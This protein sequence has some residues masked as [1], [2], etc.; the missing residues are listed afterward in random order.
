MENYN[1]TCP[2]CA[3]KKYEYIDNIGHDNLTEHDIY[4]CKDC[5][6]GFYVYITKEITKVEVGK[7]KWSGYKI[8]YEK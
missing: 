1:I 8:V 4:E 6:E 5:E 2:Y 3:S 7:N